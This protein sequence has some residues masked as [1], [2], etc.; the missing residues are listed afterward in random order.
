MSEKL[1]SNLIF[2]TDTK[3]FTI[4]KGSIGTY[5]YKEIKKCNVLYEDAKYTGKTP[6]FDHQTIGG[7]GANPYLSD[8][9]AYIGLR[10]IMK[11]G[12]ILYVY[13]TDKP[14]MLNT[15]DFYKQMRI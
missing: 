9:K 5:S 7:V 4:L 13:L 10:L 14:H 2:E 3:T 11:N 12:A 6:M 15:L 1:F 8:T